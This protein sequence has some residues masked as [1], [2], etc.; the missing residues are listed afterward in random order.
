[1]KINSREFKVIYGALYL[2]S[3]W[4]RSLAAA[5]PDDSPEFK[6]AKQAEKRYMELRTLLHFRRVGDESTKK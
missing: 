4:E 2:A 5:W 6:K 3:Q 1:M